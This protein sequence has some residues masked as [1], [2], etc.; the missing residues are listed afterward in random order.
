V[1]S[2]PLHALIAIAK[3]TQS[4]DSHKSMTEIKTPAKK[5]TGKPNP[6]HYWA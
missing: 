3:M 2:E 6:G 1:T 5:A 4:V